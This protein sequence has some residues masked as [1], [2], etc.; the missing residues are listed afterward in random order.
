MRKAEHGSGWVL[1]DVTLELE[2][3]LQK[4]LPLIRYKAKQHEDETNLE[5]EIELEE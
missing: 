4:C 3:N 5:F 1:Y 2:R